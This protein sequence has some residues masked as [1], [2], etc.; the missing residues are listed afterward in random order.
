MSAYGLG[1]ADVVQEKEEPL[2]E[3]LAN[4][5]VSE[6]LEARFAEMKRVN[7]EAILAVGFENSQIENHYYLNLR[8][9]GTNTSIMIESPVPSEDCTIEQLYSEAFERQHQL[10]FGFNFES[11][12]I[13]ID[14][15]RVR[16][17]GK[18][19]TIRATM[20]DSIE[21]GESEL[22]EPQEITPVYF[23]IGGEAKCLDTSV[24][25]LEQLKA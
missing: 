25:S 14:N 16:S 21:A 19:Q 24:Y 6:R 10:E 1:L 20:I 2:Q 22:P 7:E 4:N 12:Q 17:V 5:I 9:T 15:I 11:R 18:K 3:V 8:Y 13:L 23:E